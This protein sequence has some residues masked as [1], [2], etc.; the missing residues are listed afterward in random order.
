MKIEAFF[1]YRMA[2]TAEALS[3]QLVAVYGRTHG[4]SRGEWR[5]LFLLDDA[6]K[7]DSLQLS[8]RSSLDKVQV[9]RAAARLEARGL[10]TR[11]VPGSDRRLR[12][13]RITE[14]GRALFTRAFVE[15]EARAQEILGAVP[16]ADREAL[17][18]GIAALDRAIA[19]V[20]QPESGQGTSFARPAGAEE[21][22]AG[23]RRGHRRDCNAPCCISNERRGGV[24]RP[25]PKPC[26]LLAHCQPTIIPLKRGSRNSDTSS[27]RGS[28]IS[29]WFTGSMRQKPQ[30]TGIMMP[31]MLETTVTV[32]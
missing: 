29:S 21:T 25:Q 26:I 3:R 23:A 32:R 9:S 28:R 7:L 24:A 18:R 13:Y 5:L 14:A 1:P 31:S 19:S 30:S 22:P 2:A 16:R 12:D 20:T 6:G 17:M 10:I 15:V 11:S 8:Q 27:V 4:L